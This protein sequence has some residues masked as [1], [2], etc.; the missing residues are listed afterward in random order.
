MAGADFL[1]TDVWLSMGEPPG[2][3]DERI[4]LLLPYQVN[5]DVL[6]ATGN[7]EVKFM[8]CLPALHNRD[9][10]VGEQIYERRGLTALEVTD[11]VFESPGFRR[12][13]PGREPAAHDQGGHGRD[14]GE[15]D[16]RVVAA[17]GGN[18]LLERG[19]R[20][21][22]EIQESHIARAA[23]ALS[24]ML[25]EHDL[26]ITHG[27]GPQVGVLAIESAG[28]PS[29][30]RPYPLDVLG[31]QTQGMIGY[32]LL[33]AL[34]RAATREAARRG[35]AGPW[36][37]ARRP[38][39]PSPRSASSAGPWSRR[40][41]RRSPSRPSSSAR[42]TTRP[43]RRRLAAA[44]GWEM[45][46]DGRAWRRVVP[47]PEPAGLVELDMIRL[48]ASRGVT[49]IC[50]GG[51]GVP[52]VA[53]EEGGLRGV[54]AVV[55][56]DLTAALLA[57]D[58]GAD[59]LLLLTDVAAVQDGYGTART[60]GPSAGPPPPSCGAGCR[61]GRS[62][63]GRWAPRS[64]RPAASPRRRR[65]GCH[66][67]ARR[68]PGP[69][70]RQ[71]RND[72]RN[73]SEDRSTMTDTGSGPRPRIVVGVDGSAGA[74]HALRWAARQARYDGATLEAVTAWQ[75]PA[76]F[77]WAP[78]GADSADFGSIAE[79]TLSDALNDVFGAAMAGLGAGPVVEGYPAKILVH[80]SEGADLLVVGSRGH[81]G[82]ADALLGS[83]S[84]Y[85][86]HHAYGPVTVIRPPRRPDP[87]R[88]AG[89]ARR[90]RAHG[91]VRR[92]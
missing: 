15:A 4:D 47:S 72:S 40:T 17:L 6:A 61:P 21:D 16:M 80:A 68:C 39:R 11:E 78:V 79:K 67:L 31:A 59:A 30:S 24:P 41:T 60:P 45:R 23:A 8:H 83:V 7:P 37:R 65:D 3:W 62:R 19:E 89:G 88:P 74:A 73:G 63:P 49:V 20:P 54:E 51:G 44:R 33:Q 82:F 34:E 91:P 70:G 84:T 58:L 1:Y 35:A 81:A 32:W 13:R 42:S 29:L 86:V 52:V 26:V 69:A 57:Q 27:N 50:A 36:R 56:K 43:R 53:D 12:V 9:T 75:Y 66:R 25:R 76:F 71:G 10:E 22:A 28:D 87:D 18:A 92:E 90:A 85:C 48:L 5:A 77:G 38:V 14:P 64:R 46:R 55:D 2:E